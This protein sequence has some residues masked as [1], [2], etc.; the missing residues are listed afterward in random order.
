[1]ENAPKLVAEVGY[2]P[3]PARFYTENLAKIQ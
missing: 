3:M 2:V 1:M